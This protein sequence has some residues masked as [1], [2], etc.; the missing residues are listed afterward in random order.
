MNTKNRKKFFT[1]ECVIKLVIEVKFRYALI[2]TTLKTERVKRKLCKSTTAILPTGLYATEGVRKR[3]HACAVYDSS[4][5][6][7]MADDINVHCA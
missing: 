1:L 5:L 4:K 6:V 3:V 7:L 2:D